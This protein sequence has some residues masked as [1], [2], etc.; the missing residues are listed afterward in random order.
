MY[1]QGALQPCVFTLFT[2]YVDVHVHVHVR[3]CYDKY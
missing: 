1:A 2:L 3:M